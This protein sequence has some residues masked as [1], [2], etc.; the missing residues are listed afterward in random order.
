[1]D[2][3]QFLSKPPVQDPVQV[4]D[5]SSC[6]DPQ[7]LGSSRSFSDDLVT[8]CLGGPGMKI[9]RSRSFTIPCA[10]IF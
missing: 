6:E 8:F 2:P 4:L 3:D 1:M 9:V 10:K 5:R 7:N